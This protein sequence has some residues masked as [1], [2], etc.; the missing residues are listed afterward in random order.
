[1]TILLDVSLFQARDAEKDQTFFLCQVPQQALRYSMFP[2]GEYLKKDVKQI[3]W[4]AG[5]D[6]VALKRESR[7]ICFVGKRNFQDFISK[8]QHDKFNVCYYSIFVLIT[9]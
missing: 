7:G 8:V 9:K 3:A 6:K 4:K 5:L 2:L 1:M